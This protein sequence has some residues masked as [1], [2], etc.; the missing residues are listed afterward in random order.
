[1]TGTCHL[2]PSKTIAL[3]P[4]SPRTQTGYA[5]RRRVGRAV[6]A[7]FTKSARRA[8]CEDHPRRH[9]RSNM[10]QQVRVRHRFASGNIARDGVVN[11]ITRA[12]SH[13]YLVSRGRNM[14]SGRRRVADCDIR[15]CTATLSHADERGPPDHLEWCRA[16]D[17]ALA[18][19]R[20]TSRLRPSISSSPSAAAVPRGA[21]MRYACVPCACHCS[22]R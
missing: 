17:R 9:H 18:E 22:S 4:R 10:Q 7:T 21:T 14:S 16:A 8:L 12:I 3:V 2:A 19:Y 20:D 13:P 1:M 11:S 5:T 6:V 15:W